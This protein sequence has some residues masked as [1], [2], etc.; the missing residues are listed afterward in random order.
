MDDNDLAQLLH[1]ATELINNSKEA[2]YEVL[3]LAYSL[4]KAYK[5]ALNSSRTGVENLISGMNQQ[6]MARKRRILLS[7]VVGVIALALGLLALWN[8]SKIGAGFHQAFLIAA[9]GA[10][11]TFCLVELLLDRILEISSK[12]VRETIKHVDELKSLNAQISDK[13]REL[14]ENGKPLEE[15]LDEVLPQLKALAFPGGS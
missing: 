7:I 4:L 15:R 14:V 2:N 3:D 6:L 5:E 11:I 10:L 8:S 1:D 9:G 12:Q 13:A